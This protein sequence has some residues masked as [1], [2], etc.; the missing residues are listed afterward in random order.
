LLLWFAWQQ[1]LNLLT[2]TIT[3]LIF[4]FA[5]NISKVY[6]DT[7][8]AFYLPQTRFW[9]LLAGSVLAYLTMYKQNMFPSF[10]QKLDEWL[11]LII[12]AQA[13]EK[14]GN[15]L[16]NV[17]SLLGAILIAFGV[18][19]ITKE[20]HFPG[21]WAV[22]PTVG[23]VLIISAGT[24]AW[25]NRAVLSNR[26]LVWF[27]LISFPLYLWH[28]P[29]LSF[30]RIIESEKPSQG[31]RIAVVLISIVLAW[32][33]YK[34]IEKPIRFG[35][36]S[37][38]KT[39]TLFVLMVAVGSVGYSSYKGDGF[40]FRKIAKKSLDFTYETE[41]LGYL[42]CQNE[43][44]LSG[45]SFCL[46]SPNGKINAALIGDSHA[47][48]KFYGIA[49][50]DK[51]RNWMLI[52]NHSCPPVYGINV[53]TIVKDC[54]PKFENIID[55]LSKSNDIKI[56][57]L[58]FFGNV[59]LTT[60]YAADHIKMKVGPDTVK[61]H[62]KNSNRLSRSE[63]FFNGLNETVNILEKS[64]KQ[65]VLMIDVPEL[66][67]FPRDCYRNPYKKCQL[68]R[69]EVELRQA[70]QRALINKLKQQHPLLMIF[71]PIN[72][73]CQKDFCSFQNEDRVIY[74]DSH[75]LSLR[76]SDLYAA[77]FLNWLNSVPTVKLVAPNS[78]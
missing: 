14:N 37:T 21:W 29:L 49:K 69:S 22:F 64:G 3:V 16:R 17:Q 35:N 36:H 72:L 5:L 48:D 6:S 68:P 57:G 2:I 40:I 76:G 24:G 59:F 60:S 62:T 33:T 32:L 27:G 46:M 65:V 28:W 47:R 77:Y 44:L 20:R 70:E 52:G 66:P 55:W 51:D 9:E 39:I 31:I 43:P 4:S 8:A 75:H 63:L 78:E 54:Q 25:L 18:V 74:R 53:E 15:T 12:C 71:D 30:A 45:I 56:V 13:P 58:S 41:N 50:A 42:K 11:S 67:F 73:I 23:A 61:L 38:T 1:R 34:L 26:L 10:K 7:V 19:V